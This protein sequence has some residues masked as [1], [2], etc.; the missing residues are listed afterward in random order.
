[1]ALWVAGCL[2]AGVGCGELGLAVQD[3]A[4]SAQACLLFGRVRSPNH[5]GAP[6]VVAAYTPSQEGRD[7]EGWALTREGELFL[8]HLPAGRYFLVAL[9][10]LNHNH[11]PD[12]GEPLGIY[13]EEGVMVASPGEAVGELTL[14]VDNGKLPKGFPALGEK[15]KA[16]AEDLP[17]PRPGAVADLNSPYFAAAYG[18]VGH[19]APGQFWEEVGGNIF[20]LEP[21]DPA[22]TPLL[23]VHGAGGS[24]QD[25]REFFRRL[26]RPKYQAWFFNYPSGLGLEGMAR[27][28]SEKLVDLHERYAFSR[29]VIVAHGMGGLVVR[30]FLVDYG[31]LHPYVKVFVSI[32][33]PWGGEDLAATGRSLWPVAPRSWEDVAPGSPLLRHI[34]AKRL[35][36]PVKFYLIFG[37][38]PE[39]SL[40]RPTNDGAVTLASQ[41][42]PRALKEAKGS[43]GF[44][45]DHLSI[46]A[47]HDVLVFT[48]SLWGK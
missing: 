36:G 35:P 14:T 23:F 15:I 31:L 11:T 39:A 44:R 6:V 2:V 48:E 13:G 38:T 8:L 28:L 43:Y 42:D 33:T 46:L 40:L 4:Q 19:W 21:Y 20:F 3:Q 29:L 1:M 16:R 12:A 32:S 10:D 7:L 24:P 9:V 27:L 25:F 41:T 22:R 26:D 45:E 18:E 47:S 5:P 34:Y 30:S 37:Y 17:D